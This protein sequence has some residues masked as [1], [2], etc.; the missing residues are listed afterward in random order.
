[1]PSCYKDLKK[2]FDL[3]L[4]FL[5]LAILGSYVICGLELVELVKNLWITHRVLGCCSEF[6]KFRLKMTNK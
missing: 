4:D 1:M 2:I 5:S 6:G 3:V